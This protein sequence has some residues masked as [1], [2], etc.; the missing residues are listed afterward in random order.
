ML[1]LLGA[2]NIETK[3]VGA[4]CES[5]YLEL[6]ESTYSFVNRRPCIKA[7]RI[8]EAVKEYVSNFSNIDRLLKYYNRVLR[9]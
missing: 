5:A 9:Q 1:E 8:F 2:C 3:M 6:G 7:G 4:G